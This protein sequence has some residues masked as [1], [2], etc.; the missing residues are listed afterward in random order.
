MVDDTNRKDWVLNT[1]QVYDL[2]KR[3]LLDDPL[4]ASAYALKS[5]SFLNEIQFF[6]AAE[7]LPLDLAHDVFEGFSVDLTSN[8]LKSLVT[9]KKV[10]ST[11]I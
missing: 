10:F 7:G 2:S 11:I 6:H 4:M 3:H 8:I 1:R 5:N 9:L